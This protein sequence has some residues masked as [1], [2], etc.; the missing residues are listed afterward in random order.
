MLLSLIRI[1]SLSATIGKLYINGAFECWTLEDAFHK[2]KIKHETCIPFGVY[3]IDLRYSPR[4]TQKYGHKMLWLKEVPGFEY[5][6]IHKGNTIKDTSG[7]I[8]VGSDIRGDSLISSKDAY[9]KFYPKVA[10][11]ITAGE[12]VQIAIIDLVRNDY[13]QKTDSNISN[14]H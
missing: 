8:L 7:C 4:F 1:R 9:D 14:G 2:E 13:V 12:K 3:D 11:R 5:I 6:L 10:S